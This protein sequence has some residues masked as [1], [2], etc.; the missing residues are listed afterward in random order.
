MRQMVLL[1]AATAAAS[2]FSAPKQV[3][4]RQSGV[5]R[6]P[7]SVETSG[8]P[9][10]KEYNASLIRNLNLSGHFQVA[11][12]APIRVTGTP[13]GTVVA[14]G[15]GK[16]VSLAAPVSDAKS[17]RMAARQMADAIVNAYTGKKGFAQNRITFVDRK[18]RD[19]AEL[20]TCYP[21]GY[22]IR[23][24]TSNRR[25]VVGPRWSPNGNEIFYTGFLQ[26]TPLV[27]RIDMEGRGSLLHPFKGL[28]TGAA[29]SPD[30][31]RCAI[32]LSFQ[33]NPELYVWEF[34]TKRVIR[35][36]KTVKAAEASPCWSPDGR[37]I[38]YV[39]DETRHPQIY[40]VDVATK[41]KRRL[42]NAGGENTNP[43]WGPDGRLVWCTKRGGQ[44]F[45]AVMDPRQGEAS[46]R[47]VTEGGTWEH[48]S[49]AAN[50]RHVVAS[51][52]RALFIVD[53]DKDGDRPARLFLNPGNWM[54]PAWYR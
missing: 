45:V 25:A 43:D 27:Y 35:L 39:S 41:Q 44:N 53:T 10:A 4:V 49:W 42:T 23:Q 6:T 29:V 26:Q 54:N 17:A 8:G 46:T 14:T 30:G 12:Q 34:A 20:Y 2:A 21:D 50:G 48:P 22:D 9:A 40:V 15:A 38:A 32:I 36:T 33:G 47:L 11:A 16:Q 19:N 31:G 13:G 1:L 5:E 24:L 3:V 52:D 51:R 37:Q 18:G 28:A 7:V